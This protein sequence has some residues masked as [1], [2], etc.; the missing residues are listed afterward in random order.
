MDEALLQ[1][2]PDREAALRVELEE[3]LVV[4]PLAAFLSSGLGHCALALMK[5][6][7]CRCGNSMAQ[8]GRFDGRGHCPVRVKF[9]GMR[10]E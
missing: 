6:L 2:Q 4:V 3:V 5:R 1:L 9:I 8:Q 10:A 7:F